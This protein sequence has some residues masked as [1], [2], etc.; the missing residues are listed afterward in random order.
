MRH[1]GLI[2]E[3]IIRAL[4]FQVYENNGVIKRK[5]IEHIIKLIPKEERKKLWNMG[6]K[7]GKYH[8]YLPRMLKPNAVELRVKL[9][10][11]FYP[12]DKKYTIPKSGLNFLKDETLRNYKF[13]LICGFENFNKF[14]VR[15]DILERLFLKVIEN[16]LHYSV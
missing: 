4:I 6:V 15:V 8:V 2:Q 9:W 16:I 13:L 14:Y 12:G 10:K 5:K 1:S 7:I 11:L 3:E